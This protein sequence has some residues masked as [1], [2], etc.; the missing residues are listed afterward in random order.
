MILVGQTLTIGNIT[1]VTSKPIIDSFPLLKQ[2]PIITGQPKV[3]EGK[4]T[5]NGPIAPDLATEKGVTTQ[6]GLPQFN[7]NIERFPGMIS[8]LAGTVLASKKLDQMTAKEISELSSVEAIKSALPKTWSF[9]NNNGF[10]HVKDETGQYRIRIDPMDKTNPSTNFPHMH[11]YNQ[12][13]KSLDKTGNVVDPSSPE[14][15][16]KWI[17]D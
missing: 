15:H 12:N 3:N 1:T 17:G 8:G 4:T 9:Y 5:I 16:I 2:K 11:I 7:G 6:P 10:V 13:G 14:A